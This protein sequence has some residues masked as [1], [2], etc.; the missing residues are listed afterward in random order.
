MVTLIVEDLEKRAA[1]EAVENA[2]VIFGLKYGEL[3]SALG[4]DRRT[5]H[6]YRTQTTAPSP[7]VQV[8]IDRLREIVHLLSEVFVDRSVEMQWLYSPVSLLR[9][10]RPID[11]IKRG[12]LDEVLAVLAGLYSGASS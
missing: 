10:R 2:Y 11:L 8:R 1:E 3:A 7:R 5:L 4:V 12:E 6:R 9:G